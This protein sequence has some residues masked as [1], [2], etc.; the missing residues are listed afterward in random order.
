MILLG[1][2]ISFW[3]HEARIMDYGSLSGEPFCVDIARCALN[4]GDIVAAKGVCVNP[5]AAL[6]LEGTCV[7]S[8]KFLFNT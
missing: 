8:K 4:F 2:V 5:S 3:E 7:R 1:E 6:D